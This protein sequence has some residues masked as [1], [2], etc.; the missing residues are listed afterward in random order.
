ME[1]EEFTTLAQQDK[2]DVLLELRRYEAAIAELAQQIASEPENPWL[3]FQLARAFVG[4]EDYVKARTACE[5]AIALNPEFSWAF[6]L[7]SAIFHQLHN[8]DQ[9]LAMAE[10][11]VRLDAEEAVFLTRLAHAQIQSGMPRKALKTAEAAIALD[12]ESDETH[13]LIGHVSVELDLYQKAEQHFRAALQLRADDPALIN[14]LARALMGQKKWPAAITTLHQTIQLD[15]AEPAFQDNLY[16]AIE[17]WLA[18]KPLPQQKAAA[19]SE[20]PKAIQNFYR[21]RKARTPIYA[22]P[23]FVG[24][25]VIT[26]ILLLTIVF[27]ALLP[28]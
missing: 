2:V 27:N 26:L 7:L 20:L 6:Y 3:R 14:D 28:L 22:N 9:E 16:T 4:L 21:D 12:P 10:E 1:S 17:R 5:E 13:Q 25:I 15:P 8:F 18:N 19:L 24:A 11:A 23:Y